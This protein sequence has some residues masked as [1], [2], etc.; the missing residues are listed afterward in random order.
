M[1]QWRLLRGLAVGCC[2]SIL[3]WMS[4]F[5]APSRRA[6]WCTWF[7]SVFRFSTD[8]DPTSHRVRLWRGGSASKVLLSRLFFPRVRLHLLC[9]TSDAVPSL[10][11]S[12]HEE[13]CYGHDVLSHG[14]EVRRAPPHPLPFLYAVCGSFLLSHSARPCWI[15]RVQLSLKV[16]P[17]LTKYWSTPGPRGRLVPV[18]R[19]RLAAWHMRG[20]WHTREGR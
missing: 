18:R 5:L 20:H 8:A 1:V 9:S 2:R 13:G 19:W 15:R 10:S 17:S 7:S 6:R 3:S 4:C 16:S 11:C 14:W 12:V